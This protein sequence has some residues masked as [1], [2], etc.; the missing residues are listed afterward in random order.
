MR[1]PDGFPR[2]TRHATER[3]A[4]RR[5]PMEGVL[6]V[7]RHGRRR[8]LDDGCFAWGVTGW[9]LRRCPQLRPYRLLTVLQ[10]VATGEIVTAYWCRAAVRATAEPKRPVNRLKAYHRTRRRWVEKGRRAS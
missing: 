10:D 6:L 8:R 7:L 9:E 5:I 2:F 1:T 4:Q 3:M